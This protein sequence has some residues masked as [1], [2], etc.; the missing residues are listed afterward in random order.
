M[1]APRSPD[2]HRQRWIAR[3]EWIVAIALTTAAIFLQVINFRHAGALWR[4]EVAAVN[5]AQMP[6]W[7]A[8]WSNLEHE[9]F[10]L[11]I[12]VLVRIWTAVGFGGSDTGLRALGLVISVGILA[13]L[14]WSTWSLVRRPPLLSLLLIALSPVA[15]RWGGSLRAYGLGVLLAVVMVATI[16]RLVAGLTG[17]RVLFAAVVSVL[18]LHA[19]YQNGLVLLALC[20]AAGPVAL[21]RR[22]AK[23]ALALGAV[24]FVSALSLLPYIGVIKRASEW[25]EATA[26]AIDFER[27][28]TIL[29]RAL[30]ASGG[31]MPWL[32]AAVICAATII[33]VC[34]IVRQHRGTARPE[35]E[36]SLFLVVTVAIMT[37]AYYAFVKITKFPT[38]E[39]YYLLWMAIAAVAA[40]ALITRRIALTNARIA[41]VL[42]VLIAAAV[43]LPVALR[44]IHVRT[45][46]LDLVAAR[47]NSA[48][49]PKDV[50]IVHPWF[51]AVT[52][53]RYYDGPA[54]L[55]TL[56]PVSDV[57]L[58]RL[59]LV[60]EQMRNQHAMQPVLAEIEAALRIGGTVWLVGHFPFANPP[61]PAPVLPR[62]GEGPEGWRAAPYMTAYGM[63]VAYFL[64]RHALQSARVELPV[65]QPVH[66]FED[67]PVRALAGW[68][69]PRGAR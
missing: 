3:L 48:V 25:N 50:V 41:Q 68:R 26:V 67:L 62:A 1:A 10:P 8:I 42:A 2:S 16:W 23:L 19:L 55:L 63:E 39:W 22:D 46:N 36:F 13:A 56:P 66:P 58:Q 40:D 27:V 43:A 51:C 38:E 28:W 35:A 29:H 6:S 64:Q 5:L 20:A 4:D 31:W 18:A 33:A 59:D 12:T 65:Q 14:W 57:K 9:S 37:V 45:S 61:Q 53:A 54:K 24:G 44:V 69:E 30:S 21:L 60:K 15:L 47:L 34:S 7:S 52:L 49:A 17:K 32:W 11:L